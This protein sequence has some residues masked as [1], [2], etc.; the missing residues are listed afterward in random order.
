MPSLFSLGF[1]T[2]PSKP[3]PLNIFLSHI[4]CRFV[5]QVF[6]CDDQRGNA[7]LLTFILSGMHLASSASF[8]IKATRAPS[9]KTGSKPVNCVDL[10]VNGASKCSVRIHFKDGCCR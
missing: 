9:N 3:K 4:L 6:Y 5:F 1:P 7:A 10:Q 8:I 2:F